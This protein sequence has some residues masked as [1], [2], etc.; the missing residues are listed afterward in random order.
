MAALAAQ[1]ERDMAN[2]EQSRQERLAKALEMHRSE[3]TK[4]RN[5]W[6]DCVPRECEY[7]CK[8]KI[9]DKDYKEHTAACENRPWKCELCAEVI[10]F[11]RVEKHRTLICV[12]RMI[13]CN[14]GECN[15]LRMKA[16]DKDAHDRE[17]HVI[18][19]GGGGGQHDEELKVSECLGVSVFASCFPLTIVDVLYRWNW[20][21]SQGTLKSIQILTVSSKT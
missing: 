12:E 17:H 20:C 3:A 16:L 6:L 1:K 15:K 4:A 5:F 18:V 21:P 13:Y 7:D 19:R 2:A 9:L 14:R 11:K 8:S 10:K